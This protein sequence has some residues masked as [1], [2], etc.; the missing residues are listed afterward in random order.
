MAILDYAVSGYKYSP[1]DFGELTSLA[2]DLTDFYRRLSIY[3][4]QKTKSAHL[5][6]EVFW[7]EN[8][9]FT[10]KQCEV[11]GKLAP[12]VA[13]EIREYLEGLLYAG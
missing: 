7:C 5:D 13:A 12:Y 8:M 2:E 4:A 9:Y 1:E 6:L 11:M 3:N 10:I